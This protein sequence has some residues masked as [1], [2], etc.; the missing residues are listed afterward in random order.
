MTIHSFLQ[1]NPHIQGSNTFVKLTTLLKAGL[2]DENMSSTTDRD[3]FTRIMMLN[4]KYVVVDE[5]L[6]DINA[7][8]DRNRITNSSKKKTDGLKKF[9]HKYKGFMTDEDKSLFFQRIH[10]L[11][12]VEESSIKEELNN[13]INNT[14][15][16]IYEKHDFDKTLVIGFIATEYDLG[17]RLLKQIIQIKYSNIK[18]LVIKNNNFNNKEYI[19]IIKNNSNNISINIISHEQIISDI[20]SYKINIILKDSI[21]S[22]T[23]KDIAISRSILNEYLYLN[24]NDGD[25]IWVLD[26]DMELFELIINKGI[27]LKNN[28]DIIGIISKYRNLYDAVVG[29]YSL[30]P[31]L[32]NFS[33]IRCSLIDFMYSNIGNFDGFMILD[34]YNDYYYDLSDKN[35]S[36]LETP[37]KINSKNIDDVFS[38]KSLGRPLFIKNREIKEATN[39]GGNTIIFKRELLKIPNSSIKVHDLIGRRSDYFWVLQAKLKGFEI[40]NIPFS[41]LHNKKYTKLNYQK[42]EIKL[43]K[44][45]IGSSFTKTIEKKGLDCSRHEFFDEYHNNY[46]NRLIKYIFSYYRIIGLLHILKDNYYLQYY[47]ENNLFHFIKNTKKYNTFEPVISSYMMLKD[48][49]IK[50]QNIKYI[51]YFKSNIHLLNSSKL[52]ILGIGNEGIVFNC[53]NE[54]V[55]KCFYKQLSNKPLL[56]KINDGNIYGIPKFDLLNINN[57][58]IIKYKFSKYEKYDSG[59]YKDFSILINNLREKNIIYT[60]FK[61]ENFIIIDNKIRL[62]DLGNSFKE[63][64]NEEE[65]IKNVKRCFQMLRYPFLNKSEFR[66][67]IQYAYSDK[68]KEIDSG[69]NIFLD[70]CKKRYKEELHD[71]IIIELINK[72]KPSNILDFGAGKCKIA[73]KLSDKYKFTVYDIDIKTLNE[74][75]NKN[76][77]IKTQYDELENTYDMIINNLVLCCVNNEIVDDILFK[78]SGK[79]K[80]G[81]H[82][83]FSIC[84]PFFNS[85]QKTELRNSGL[86]ISYNKSEIF[87]KI[88]NLGGL[89]RKEY[90]RPIEYYIS[91]LQKYGF[92]IEYSFEGKGVNVETMLPIAEHLILDCILMNKPI[93]LFDCSLLIKS[94]PMEAKYIYENIKHIILS[95]Q[96]GIIFNKVIVVIDGINLESRARKYENDDYDLLIS[97]INRA[98]L[99]H[100]ID[101]YWICDNIND[102]IRINKKF[103]GIEK[104]AT[105]SIN[106]QGTFATLYAFD[107]INTKYVFQTDSDILYYNNDINTFLSAYELCKNKPFVCLSIAHKDNLEQSNCNRIEVRTCFINL[108]NVISRIPYENEIINCKYK[109]T[110]HRAF[111]KKYN[112]NDK[113]RFHNNNIYFIH[114]KNDNKNLNELNIY[115]NS[116]ESGMLIEEQINKVNLEPDIKNWIK[117]C[118]SNVI[119]Y[120]R[121]RNIPNEKIKRMFDSLKNQTYKNFH[122]IYVDDASDNF[123]NDYAKFILDYDNYFKLKNIYIFNKIRIGELANLYFVMKNIVKNPNSIVINLDSDDYFIEN[124]AIEIIVNEFH[125]GADVTCGNCLRY[126]KPLNHY[127]IQSFKNIWDRNGDN[128]WLHPK[129]FRRRLFDYVTEE[130]L[131]INDKYIEVNTDFAFMTPIICNAQNPV[132]IDKLL[133]YFEPSIDNQKSTNNY[134]KKNKEYIR[135]IILERNKNKYMEKYPS[136]K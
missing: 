48:D 23:I 86:K 77:V 127:T 125:K 25:A 42:E 39:R 103:F 32:P 56:E 5:Y 70:M 52:E 89:I 78:I 11:F 37:F 123:S 65:Y 14:P 116:I 53:N 20:N 68:T 28:I 62:I 81:H 83:I 13:K 16:I 93:N 24:S 29:N 119:V 67:L 2:F 36:H 121:G 15:N 128:I 6:T 38:G 135:N 74:R 44:D 27:I 61:K 100:L 105:H 130:D 90:H 4:P 59:L 7:F 35:N 19:N 18:I 12:N 64:S 97:E 124:K 126:D 26:E 58:D 111:D 51:D 87:D 79:V 34:D 131:K 9:Y 21:T 46:E 122:I 108:E 41:T 43:L 114:P 54:Y 110:W 47:N 84:N 57:I 45:L 40:V 102:S 107:K 120:I 30:D 85:V 82:V 3:I 115:R 101:E 72:Y 55:Y 76:I 31:P 88:T 17:L 129:C 133:Y 71:D 112:E 69:Y 50:Y 106:G 66:E 99:N 104:E 63:Y 73:N 75:A 109:D 10:N 33:T 8:N 134:N 96:K 95:L 49:I 94:N 80:L 113:I 92:K 118:D 1:K 98:K 136:D 91:K 132:F 60:N 117:K 22:P